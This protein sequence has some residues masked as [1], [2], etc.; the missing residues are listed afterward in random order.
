[1]KSPARTVQEGYFTTN[2]PMLPAEE[3]FYLPFSRNYFCE[4]GINK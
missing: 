1:M 4:K 3:T 2:A